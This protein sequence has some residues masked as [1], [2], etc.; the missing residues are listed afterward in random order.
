[1]FRHKSIG[2]GMLA[3]LLLL[4][5][6]PLWQGWRAHPL[7]AAELVDVC[8]LARP[9]AVRELLETPDTMT[10]RMPGAAP[11]VVE[12]TCQI[13]LAADAER[14]E[15]ARFVA[16]ALITERGLV[17]RGARQGSQVFVETWLAEARASGS[18]VR[19]VAGPWRTAATVQPAREDVTGLQ[20][21]ADDAGVILWFRAEGVEAARLVAFAG[22]TARA[23]RQAKR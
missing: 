13:D 22:A 4:L 2:L 16:A 15:P 8:D 23:A 18:R 9:D 7:A 20:L 21:L 3:I 11:E 6:L 10:S 14:P 1:M 12:P 17:R 19:D 5:G